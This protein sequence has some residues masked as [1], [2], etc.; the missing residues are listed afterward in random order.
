ME[1]INVSRWQD[2]VRAFFGMRGDNPVPTP[3]ELRPV[4][5]V[6]CDRPEWGLS[7][8]ENLYSAF[9]SRAGVVAEFAYVALLNPRDSGLICVVEG[10]FPTSGTPRYFRCRP[11]DIAATSPFLLGQT[12]VTQ[13]DDSLNR[14]FRRLPGSDNSGVSGMFQVIGSH[15][16][17]PGLGPFFKHPPTTSEGFKLPI[18]VAPN[19]ALLLRG[20]VVNTL[21]ELNIVWRERPQER[22]VLS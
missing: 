5:V 13:G 7:G 8:K 22:G 18:I 19:S 12:S 9:L 3:A 11:S 4:V 20:D 2:K 16:T 15:A 10:V 17:P 6:E 1:P 21:L 14:D